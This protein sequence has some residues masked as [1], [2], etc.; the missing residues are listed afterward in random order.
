MTIQ[1]TTQIA[2]KEAKQPT[3]LNDGLHEKCGVFGIIAPKTLALGHLLYF[4]LY[5]LQHRG[6]ESCGMAVFNND[7]LLLHKNT[8]LVNQVFDE[9]VL[10]TLSGQIGIGHTR[11]TTAGDNSIENAQPVVS[12][13]RLGS[14]VLAHNGNLIELET[15]RDAFHLEAGDN[16]GAN[17]DSHV[18]ARCIAQALTQTEGNLAQATKAV[19]EQC[20]GAFSV[21]VATGDCLIAAR[22]RNGIRPLSLG[23]TEQGYWVVASETCALDIVGAT[24]VRDILPGEVLTIHLN[25]TME[26]TFVAGQKT[27]N[28]CIF[29]YVYFA[30]PDSQFHGQTV[31][32]SRLKMGE[33]LAKTHP[34]EADFVI[35]V[36]DSGGPAAIGYS[37]ASGIPYAEGL[38]KNRY[39][40]RTFIHPTPE[41]RTQG[42]RLK[43]NPLPA[44]LAGKRVVIIDDS[45]V[46]GNTSQRIVK[47]LKDCGAKEVHFRVSSAPVKHPCFY[48][49]DMSTEAELIAN[50][51][52]LDALQAYLGVDSLA[53]LSIDD[54]KQ[55]VVPT[56][57]AASTV[58]AFTAPCMACFNNSYPA[59]KPKNHKQNTPL[60]EQQSVTETL[61]RR[62]K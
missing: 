28:F 32:E 3:Q 2:K 16:F 33:L 9:T 4:G 39:V 37:R 51:M 19:F 54:M 18:M 31:Y 36:P 57:S 47:M 44:V 25:G 13:S 41:L 56:H 26:S 61:L 1:K 27:E 15:L 60:V 59:G 6:Q 29:E 48:G 12:R 20:Q 23:K 46:R 14:V 7:Q 34:V 8:G 11:Y 10:A 49:I 35:P 55:A 42:I 45:I 24:F 50:Q 5:A 22:D 52:S 17:S 53:Y 62:G 21:V 40:G 38:I 58:D 30:R 43:L